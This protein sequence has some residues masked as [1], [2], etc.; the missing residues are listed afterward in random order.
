MILLCLLSIEQQP[1]SKK[2]EGG[3]CSCLPPPAAMVAIRQVFLKC[4]IVLQDASPS[5]SRAAAAAG[6]DARE[7]H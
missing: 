7:M 6:G 2:Q 5:S 1:R 3:Y 4:R